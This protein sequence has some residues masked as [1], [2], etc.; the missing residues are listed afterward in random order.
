MFKLILYVQVYSYP[1]TNL[2]TP[3]LGFNE[4]SCI[5]TESFVTIPI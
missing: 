1:C 3:H 5:S 4:R 2:A